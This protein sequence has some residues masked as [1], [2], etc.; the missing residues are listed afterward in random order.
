MEK[1]PSPLPLISESDCNPVPV[2]S[3]HVILSKADDGQLSGRVANLDGIVVKGS[4]ERDVLRAIVK[5]FKA[6]VQ[7]YSASNEEIP[8]RDS[9]APAADEF[10][11][12]IPVHL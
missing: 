8:W 5:Q 4:S 1:V 3:C 2:F 6:A 12:F 11:R 9:P 10:E 7:K